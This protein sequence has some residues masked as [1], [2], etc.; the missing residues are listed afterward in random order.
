M[1]L[2]LVLISSIAVWSDLRTRR[3]PN[4][5]TVGALVV[6][7]VFRI[8]PGG[9][10]VLP[11]VLSAGLALG[12]GFPFFLAG[13]LGAGD[14]K[15]MAGL[16]AFLE[17]ASLPEAMLVMAFFGGAMALVAAARKGLLAPTLANVHVLVL[18]LGRKTFQ[19]WK[20]DASE[21]RIVG[22]VSNPYAPA[23]VA[24]ALAGWFIR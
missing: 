9:P 15:L 17:P 20:R 6:G 7:L 10:E 16:A 19:G 18:T 13:G 11:G 4:W 2:A 21:P 8:F 24:G 5:L 12:F 3:L 23:I 22:R 14:V 1:L